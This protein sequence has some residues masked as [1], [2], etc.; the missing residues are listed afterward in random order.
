[1]FYAFAIVFGFSWGGLSTLTLALIGDIF[2]K[3]SI[4]VILGVQVAY[5]SL[6]AAVGPAAGGFIFDVSGNYFTA[7]ITG[8]VGMLITTIFVALVKRKMDIQSK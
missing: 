1:M 2:G 8:A 5:F 4:G 6:G 7:F 3:R